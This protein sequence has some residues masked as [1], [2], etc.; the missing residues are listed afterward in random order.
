MRKTKE[1]FQPYNWHILA[2]SLTIL[3]LFSGCTSMVVGGGATVGTAAFQE[4]GVTGAAKDL[5]TAIK[6][7]A[8]L[9]KAGEDFIFGVNVSVYEGRML[10]TGMLPKQEMQ[11][12]TVSLAWKTDGV[13]EVINEIQIGTAKLRDMGKDAWIS[14]QLHSKITLDKN[15]LAINYSIKTVNKIIYLIGIAQSQVE[16]N[17]VL[18]HAKNIDYVEKIIQHVRI[19]KS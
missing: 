2:L 9:T 13:K 8:K 1:I 3:I 19:K 17:R 16:L 14:T 12:L 7:R 11:A 15:I 5:A 10:L 6:M 4:R 18:E